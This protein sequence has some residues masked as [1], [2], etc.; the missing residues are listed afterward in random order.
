MNLIIWIHMILV[1]I[2]FLLKSLFIS[3]KILI[4]WYCIFF[5]RFKRQETY[6]KGHI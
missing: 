3:G 2:V 1:N 6:A 4:I 5:S